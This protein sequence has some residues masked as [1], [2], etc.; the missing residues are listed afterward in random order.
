MEL[1]KKTLRRIFFGAAGL[2]VLY[3]LLHET[4]RI[5]NLLHTGWS[6][7]APF[8]V[9][10]AVAFILN[11]PMRWIER[12][13]GGIRKKKLRRALAILL[14]LVCV[15][16][17]L[18]GVVYLLVPQLG[19]TVESLVA[20]LPGF[21]QR[22][23]TQI[24]E[25]L[26]EHP[27]LMEWL[28]ENTDFTSMN[29]SEL[30]QKAVS[31]ISNGLGAIMD[32][33]LNAV[34]RLSTGVFN[35]VMSLVFGI[36]CLARKEILARQGRRILYSLLPEKICDEVVRILRMT[37]SVFSNFISGQ[38]LE[39]VILGC[40]FA[41]SMAIFQMPYISLI[42]VMI[43]VMALVPII[44]AFVGCI[45]GAFFIMVQNPVLAFWFVIM[46]LI[47]QQ[48]EGNMI[49]PRVV[50]TSIGLPGMWVLVAVAVGGDL[51]GIGGML[52]MIPLTSVFYALA[53]EFTNK[54]IAER[55]ID[56]DKLRDHPPELKSNFKEKRQKSKEKRLLKQLSKRKCSDNGQDRNP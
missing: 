53:R 39:A 30:I 13:L 4:E 19:Q 6:V 27:E 10:A 11:V 54:R 12:K 31:W 34:V 38:C 22:M 23:Q 20:T 40:M 32:G 2:V 7:L 26:S 49:Y 43:A 5:T 33:A 52:L 35:A 48:I 16:L 56:R 28:T 51:M 24:N 17:V 3:W 42:S 18:I 15:I 25:Y 1:N 44:G 50:G 29:W 55:G 41:V 36:Y 47:L 21:F 14:T 46:F 37:N 9:G 45:V 8:L